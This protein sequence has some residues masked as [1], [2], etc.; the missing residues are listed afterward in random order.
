MDLGLKGKKAVITGGT[1]GIGLAIAEHLA[2]EGCDVAVCARS[3][4]S[5]KPTVERLQAIGVKA[6]GGAVDVT[7]GQALQDWIAEAAD[8]LG[9]LDIVVANVSGFGV[10]LDEAG[11]RKGFDAD[12]LGTFHAVEGAMPFLERSDAAAIAGIA[13]TAGVEYFG[14]VRPYNAVKAAVINYLAN[15][16]V[17]LAPKGI[18]ANTVSPGTV[19]FAGS[20]WDQRRQQAPDIYQRALEHNPTGRMGRPDEVAKAVTFLVSPAASFITGANLIVDGA[21]TRRVQY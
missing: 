13:S 2:A 19:F 5:I 7:D 4:A 1:R 18:R 21:L 8:G 17:A 11:W 14:G 20:V 16:A 10:S 3:A 9:G 6:T 15:L 12:V